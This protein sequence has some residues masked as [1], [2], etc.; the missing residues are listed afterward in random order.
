[1]EKKKKQILTSTLIAGAVLGTSALT[2]N[3]NTLF[4]YEDLGSGAEIR[5]TLATESIADDAG[6]YSLE[7]K[8]GEDSKKA[9]KKDSKSKEA[10]CGE[11]KCGADKKDAKSKDAKAEDK[12]TDSKSKEAKC[13][14]GKCGM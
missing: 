2:A 7:M 13:G 1:M 10:K 14:E 3:A 6:I 4:S 9:K 5:T 12:K 8:C 11:G